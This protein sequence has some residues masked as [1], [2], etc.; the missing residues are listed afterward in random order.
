MVLINYNK[1]I[2]HDKQARIDWWCATLS[3]S[4]KENDIIL[5]SGV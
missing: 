1:F 4:V 3:G 2:S 5:D